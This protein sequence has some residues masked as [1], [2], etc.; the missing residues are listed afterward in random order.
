MADIRNKGNQR[1][2]TNI[3]KVIKK[4]PTQNS[5]SANTF[6]NEGKTKTFR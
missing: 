4:K 3:F 2:K 5:I 6:K 1:E